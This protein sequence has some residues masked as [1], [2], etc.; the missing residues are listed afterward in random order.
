MRIR[1]GAYSN[2]NGLWRDICSAITWLPSKYSTARVPWPA[3]AISGAASI[4]EKIIKPCG[5]L[6]ATTAR[7][8]SQEPPRAVRSATAPLSN[9]GAAVSNAS[10]N[11]SK[12]IPVVISSR[13]TVC[14]VAVA[15]MVIAAPSRGLSATPS[16]GIT[17][18]ETLF[19]QAVT[20]VTANPCTPRTPSGTRQGT[21]IESMGVRVLQDDGHTLA[22]PDTN[23]DHSVA[24]VAFAKFDRQRQDVASAGRAERMADR[25]SSPVRGQLVVGHSESV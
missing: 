5:A 11:V 7:T 19:G 25:D 13:V 17:C 2:A 20:V 9:T 18:G 4:D 6:A 23:A 8:S 21:S 3:A 15:A 16:L 14:C 12:G 22:R 10:R 1:S 24:G